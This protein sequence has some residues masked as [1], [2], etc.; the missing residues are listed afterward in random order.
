MADDITVSTLGSTTRVERPGTGEPAWIIPNPRDEG[1]WIVFRGPGPEAM[2]E[3]LSGGFDTHE[4]ALEAARTWVS[5]GEKRLP[6]AE[7]AGVHVDPDGR[8][9]MRDAVPV[10][11]YMPGWLATIDSLDTGQRG[12]VAMSREECERMLPVLSTGEQPTISFPLRRYI[13]NGEATVVRIKAARER[14]NLGIL[15]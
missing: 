10:E 9:I 6:A 15:D 12:A 14:I 8:W 2:T 5:T 13:D 11:P 4:E 3:G 7:A 1:Y